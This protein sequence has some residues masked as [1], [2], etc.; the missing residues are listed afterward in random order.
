MLGAAPQ[1]RSPH[2]YQEEQTQDSG[3]CSTL[4][5]NHSTH[6]PALTA[7]TS[8]TSTSAASASC[9]TAILE[10]LQT[11]CG[12]ALSSAA[13]LV[14]SREFTQLPFQSAVKD[15]LTHTHTPT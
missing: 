9:Q 13:A 14:S 2:L 1:H 3:N 10:T 15:S 11:T 7:D 12:Q 5:G 8:C 4:V 6:L